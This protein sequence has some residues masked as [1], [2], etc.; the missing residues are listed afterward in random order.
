MKLKCI[1]TVIIIVCFSFQLNAQY[2]KILT[3]EQYSNNFPTDFDVGQFY[4]NTNF[5]IILPTNELDQSLQNKM[6]DF[7]KSE[8]ID[9][10]IIIPPDSLITVTDKEALLKDLSNTNIYAFGTKDGNLWTKQFLEK[11]ET[12]PFKIERDSVVAEK[13]YRGDDHIVQAVWFN[14]YNINHSLFYTFRKI[15]SMQINLKEKS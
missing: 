3:Q 4:P 6:N 13:V 11:N 9:K 14:P 15:L 10:L 1:N 2:V 5:V 8:F 12:F 7:Y